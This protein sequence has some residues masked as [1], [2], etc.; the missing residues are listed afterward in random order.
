MY[1]VHKKVRRIRT[2]SGYNY[3]ERCFKIPVVY[4]KEENK[5]R[6][7]RYATDSDDLFSDF[8]NW[9]VEDFDLK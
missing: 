6:S 9:A 1:E 3:E 8:E 4:I 7:K 5:I 2:D